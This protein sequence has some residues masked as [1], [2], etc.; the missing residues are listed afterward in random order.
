MPRS[1]RPRGLS[2]PFVPSLAQLGGLID[3]GV[4]MLQGC[5]VDLAVARITQNW[6]AVDGAC[7]WQSCRARQALS[8][9]EIKFKFHK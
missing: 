3:R 9:G 5:E 1:L 4:A 8:I 6:L 7:I 2:T